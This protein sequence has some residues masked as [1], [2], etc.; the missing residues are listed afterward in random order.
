VRNEGLWFFGEALREGTSPQRA[1]TERETTPKAKKTVF[2]PEIKFKLPHR[3]S[4][5]GDALTCPIAIVLQG[6]EKRVPDATCAH[7]ILRA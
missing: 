5:D 2:S 4:I 6:L 7:P 1:V 3:Y